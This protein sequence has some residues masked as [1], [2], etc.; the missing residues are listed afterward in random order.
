MLPTKTLN[1]R[2]LPEEHKEIKLL[3]TGRGLSIKDYLLFLVKQDLY[4]DE[5]LTEEDLKDI[6]QSEKD[7]QEG[8]TVT[9]DDYKW[10]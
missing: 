6:E 3:A 1:L 2:L 8:N 5:P 7:I 4:D 10:R 9:L